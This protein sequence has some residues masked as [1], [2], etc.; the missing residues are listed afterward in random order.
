MEKVLLV[1]ALNKEQKRILS[2]FY[3][4][5]LVEK[6]A[7]ALKVTGLG[8]ES[9]NFIHENK[10]YLSHF[11]LILNCG[12]CGSV[13]EKIKVFQKV[14][15]GIFN[16]KDK[17]LRLNENGL[18]ITTMT[19]PVY[20]KEDKVKLQCDLIDMES[21]YFAKFCNDMTISFKCLKVVSDDLN[22]M[23]DKKNHLKNLNKSLDILADE[24]E[25]F[26]KLIYTNN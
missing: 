12:V 17:S 23:E 4:R 25:N 22:T 13:S 20:K 1:T 19:E 10:E 2:R 16:L 6:S 24:V 3:V 7:I 5:N 15:P 18:S 21:F 9:N 26:I 11:D 8:I 14:E